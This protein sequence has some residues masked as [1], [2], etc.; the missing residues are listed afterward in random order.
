MGDLKKIY[1]KILSDGSAE[2]TFHCDLIDELD[3]DIE[4]Q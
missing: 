3:D 4:V 2:Y 1:W